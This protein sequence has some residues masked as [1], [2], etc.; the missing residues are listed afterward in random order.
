MEQISLRLTFLLIKINT[1]IILEA[2]GGSL[3]CGQSLRLTC[4]FAQEF[5]VLLLSVYH[6][7]H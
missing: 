3:M 7:L 4:E 1:L 6:S 2:L 5:K